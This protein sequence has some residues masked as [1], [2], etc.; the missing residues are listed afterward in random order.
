MTRAQSVPNWFVNDVMS[1][2][3]T[4][5]VLR[6]KFSPAFDALGATADV[7]VEVLY[8]A[9][10]WDERTDRE[11]LIRAFKKTA[12]QHDHWPAPKNVLDAFDSITVTLPPERRIE[13]QYTSPEQAKKNLAEIQAKIKQA[14]S[15]IKV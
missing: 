2:L 5:Y 4:F 11:R 15:N 9:R 6:L 1:G 13:P 10:Q 12:C 8:S 14:H 3:Q 7:W